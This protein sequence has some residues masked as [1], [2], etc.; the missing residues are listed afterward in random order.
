MKRPLLPLLLALL[1]LALVLPGCAYFSFTREPTEQQRRREQRYDDATIRTEIISALL[2]KDPA[3]SNTIS[4]RSF[5][6]HV[7]LIGEADKAFRVE[8]TNIARSAHD[9]AQVTT[10]WFPAG[11]TSGGA[12]AIIESNIESE[13]LRPE[14]VRARNVVADVWGGHVVL[15]GLVDNQAQ[16]DTAMAKIKQMKQVKSVTSYVTLY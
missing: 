1:S 9:V 8:A 15:T 13:V 3:K 10:H 6:G 7:F 16:I 5:D 12:D 11:T 14:P 4:V 2:R